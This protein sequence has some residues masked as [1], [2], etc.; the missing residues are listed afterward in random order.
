MLAAGR[1]KSMTAPRRA[2]FAITLGQIAHARGQ[3]QLAWELL[4]DVL[5]EGAQHAPE[6]ITHVTWFLALLLAS[7]IAIDTDDLSDALPWLQAQDHWLARTGAVFGQPENRLA[8]ASWQRASGH[9]VQARELAAQALELAT[10]PRRPLVLLRANRLLGDLATITNDAAS[11]DAHLHASLQLA[12]RCEAPYERA[13]SL[14]SL[15]ELALVENREDDAA[16]C[17]S[18]ARETFARLDAKPALGR[19]G[20]LEQR[21]GRRVSAAGLPCGLSARELEVLRLAAQ[22]LTN[23]QIGAQLF[24][25]ARTV[26]HHLRSIYRK[27]DVSTRAAAT[28]FAVEHD[29]L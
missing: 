19:V 4:G 13:L 12:E 7:E 25:S 5:P 3:T 2:Y 26:E 22:G 21:L 28:R 14:A 29:L 1:S 27:F 11:A 24:L 20:A 23:P 16:R 9:L 6:T 18:E 10:T 15:A 17:L 8:W